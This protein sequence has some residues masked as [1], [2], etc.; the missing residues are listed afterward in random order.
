MKKSILFSG[1]IVAF[2]AIVVSAAFALNMK[3]KISSATA[4][5]PSYTLVT[6][7]CTE[8]EVNA[9]EFVRYTGSDESYPVT[10]KFAGAYQYK[11]SYLVQLQGGAGQASFYNETAITGLKSIQFNANSTFNRDFKIYYGSSLDAMQGYVELTSSDFDPSA[12]AIAT[13]PGDNVQYFSVVHN[14]T[15]W[16]VSQLT[17]FTLTYSCAETHRGEAFTASA[18]MTKTPSNIPLTETFVFDVKF[19][20]TTNTHITFILGDG[21]SNYFGYYSVYKNG[22]TG[23]AYDGISVKHLSDGYL[24]VTINLSELTDVT[25]TPAKIN[26]FYVRPG[27]TDGNGYIDLSP[28]M[29]AFENVM[30]T[31]AF[32]NANLSRNVALTET[33]ILDVAFEAGQSD[34]EYFA[35]SNGSWSNFYGYYGIYV[36]GGISDKNGITTDTI[37]VNHFIYKMDIS[38]LTVTAGDPTAIDCI[39]LFIT[40]GGKTGVFTVN[41]L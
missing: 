19:T 14:S 29:T 10:F 3:N 30:T 37:G 39:S 41:V 27:W 26:L 2:S 40:S 8:T 23:A 9:G 25:G 6:G 7:L 36:T 35:F 34:R 12:G 33:I 16:N 5:D 17:S 20:D 4:V 15:G 13:F 1:A 28:N 24:R 31:R 38:A 22:V 18:G 21:W 11:A 32:T